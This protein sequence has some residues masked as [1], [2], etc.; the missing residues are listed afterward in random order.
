MSSGWAPIARTLRTVSLP[1]ALRRGRRSCALRRGGQ[2]APEAAE[3]DDAERAAGEERDSGPGAIALLRHLRGRR[4]AGSGC[5]VEEELGA[6][7]IHFALGWVTRTE[8]TPWWTPGRNV[9]GWL[10]S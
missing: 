7:S 10:P 3:Q 2:P 1:V 6:P 5:V 4:A 9:V 8:K